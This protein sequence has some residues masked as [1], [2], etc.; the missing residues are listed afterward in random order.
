MA[1]IIIEYTL[2]AFTYL[3]N[4]ATISVYLANFMRFDTA[5]IG[6]I[7]LLSAIASRASRILAAP[8]LNLIP[9]RHIM[10]LMCLL[11]AIGYLL[12]AQV[13]N[14]PLICLSLFMI[15][16]GYASNGMYVK[17]LVA[18]YKSEKNNSLLLRYSGLNVVFNVASAIAP[19]FSTSIFSHAGP[20]YFFLISGAILFTC[21]ILNYFLHPKNIHLTPQIGL[22]SSI[23][24]HIFDK[25]L[26]ILFLYTTFTWLLY[27]QLNSAIPLYVA[28]VLNQ[29]NLV[30]YLF[31]INASIVILLSY[32]LALLL[33][34][35]DFSPTNLLLI[36][37][38]CYLFGFIIITIGETFLYV[39]LAIILWTFAEIIMMPA[40]SVF[41][42]QITKPESLI[43]LI[44]I[45]SIALGIGEGL[46]GLIGAMAVLN[47]AEHHAGAMSFIPMIILSLIFILFSLFIRF[48][49]QKSRPNRIRAVIK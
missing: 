22:W 6:S 48:R 49:G 26:N 16:F 1:F 43:N 36:G 11:S 34:R 24:A 3:A 46:G 44:G 32:P 12:L 14:I 18:E 13:S 29:F 5:A 38:F 21:S 42:A 19:L 30:G 7:L 8:I 2:F 10:P 25:K 17:A 20:K 4:S 41:L 45:N 23:K 28:N 47:Y 15:G 35:Y 31:F 37:F 40:L 9:S 27:A 33:A 39:T